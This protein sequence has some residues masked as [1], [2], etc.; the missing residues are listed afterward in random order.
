M[1]RRKTSRLTRDLT[2]APPVLPHI[3]F[4]GAGV[5]FTVK[6]GVG[7]TDF[8]SRCRKNELKSRLWT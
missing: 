1:N 6:T 2:N 7:L 5:Y 3:T 8:L 4:P